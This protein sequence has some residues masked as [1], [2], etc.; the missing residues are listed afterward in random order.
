MA[1]T[2]KAKP[3]VIPT[4]RKLQKALEESAEQARRLAKAF[5]KTIPT[6]KPARQRQA[7]AFE[8]QSMKSTYFEDDDILQIRVTD[9]PIMREISQDW[10]T[11]ISYA[12]DGTIVEIAL[13]DARKERLLPLKFRKEA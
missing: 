7:G 4:G 8:R 13:L 10:H 5:G 1:Q 6:D 11:N 2:A 3:R 12:E 9:K